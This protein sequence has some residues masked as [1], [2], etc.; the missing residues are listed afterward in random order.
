MNRLPSVFFG[1]VF[2]LS[3]FYCGLLPAEDKYAPPASP[4]ITYNFNA[5][6]KFIKQDAPGAE[7]PDFDDSKWATVSTPHTYNDEDSFDEIIGGRSGEKTLYTGPACY[8]KH[9]RLPAE[10][11]GR[12]VFIEFEGM[13]QAG[14]FFV[15][16]K[17][18]G[19]Y[20]NGVTPCG[21]DITDAVFFGDKENVLTVFV[22]NVMNYKEESSGTV[23]QW[24]SKDFNPNYGG[25]NRNVWLH[26]TG[27]TYQ[28][29]PLY[30]N[31]KTLGT[32]IYADDFD[33]PAK[34]ATIN[35][36]SQ[37]RN[38]SGGQQAVE[39]SAMVVDADGI[40]RAVLKGDTYDMVDG[41]TAVL[42]AGGQ[43][44]GARWWSPNDP[45]LYDVYSILS[46][47]GKVV[48]VNKIQT[49]FRKTSFRGGAGKGSVYI[50]DRFVYLK[51]YAQRSV[52]EW[53][54]V[55]GAYPDWMHD[56]N[57]ELIRAGNGN[58]IRWMHIAPKPQNVR[59]CDRF[60]I[61]QICPA[62][63][64]EKDAEGR[65]WEQRVDV[66]RDTII[67]YRNNPSILFWEAGNNGVSPA[68]MR[69]MVELRKELDPNGGRVMGCRTLT[70][71]GT[72]NI[73]EFFE[74][75][76]GQAPE[77]DALKKPTDMF[78]AFSQERRD[79][80]PII[81]TED[82]RD[83]AAR[84]FW[85][86]YSPPHFGF[87]PGPDDTYHW[88]SETFCLAAAGRYHDYYSQI[89]TN[90]DPSRSKW[91]GYA[92]IIFADSNQ[93][94][95]QASSEVCRTSGKVDAV[96]LPKQAYF[97]H[98]VMQND[99]P[100]IHI[101]GH[102]TYPAGTK[103]TMYVAGNH[104]DAVE[105][106]V[107]GASKGKVTEP[108]NGY[109]Y[110]FKDIAFEPGTTKAVGIKI[111]HSHRPL[112]GEG[113]GPL[114]SNRTSP[115]PLGEGQGVRAS[116]NSSPLPLG[117]SPR[118]YPG[119]RTAANDGKIV[120]EHELTTAGEPKALKLT[121]HTGPKGLLADGSDVAFIDF[122][123]TDA[124]GRR[125]PTDESRVDF[126][127]TGP[128]IWRGGY[129]SGIPGS[130]NNKYLSTECGINRVFIRST[131][132]PGTIKLK[133]TR[134]GLESAK[135][136]IESLPIKIIDGLVSDPPQTLPG[137]AKKEIL[138]E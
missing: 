67:Y 30:E 114:G 81:E 21:I 76:I 45:Y 130:T 62:G 112:A 69:Q 126:D 84:R 58:Y 56:Y 122:E 134:E 44:A 39:F 109:I 91:S 101:I 27:K 59:A 18:V 15:N 77:T 90:T 25:L 60:G 93:H 11:E 83:E 34:T 65:Q 129:N 125:C 9:F 96:R 23:F 97:L 107:N 61:V 85:D 32:Y 119:V 7:K 19:I 79:L 33:I 103:K 138:T 66:M 38:E 110:A 117:E 98:R 71:K 121:A 115:L 28:T 89:I 111:N 94:G 5:A 64:K 29:F 53:A 1:I 50:N 41:E 106:F 47:D 86:D 20:E 124:Q 42:K 105:L 16:G 131:L 73:A 137:A 108:T 37:V 92:S 26:L 40:A 133:A 116:D 63:D 22:T 4:R 74:V 80:A 128:A 43:L 36:E 14:R 52:D 8:R 68:H 132:T 51:G 48:D 46:V 87:K 99:E 95:R 35:V 17:P 118:G 54:A 10:A 104:L 12:K 88:N 135:V 3:I 2:C 120:C 72:T 6:W 13:R 75:M 78:R 70:D 82:F 113:Q 123:V 55:G 49:G 57:I 102:W 127:L 136:R 31:L 24:E 100:D